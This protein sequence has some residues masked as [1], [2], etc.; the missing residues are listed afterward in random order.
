M[1]SVLQQISDYLGGQRVIS[2]SDDTR[3]WAEYLAKVIQP[4]LDELAALKAKKT[5]AAA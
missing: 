2:R 5:K 1:D 4:Q 3:S